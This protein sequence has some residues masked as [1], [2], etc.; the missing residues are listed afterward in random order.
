M[1]LNLAIEV[2]LE[3]L[4]GGITIEFDVPVKQI[5]IRKEVQAEKRYSV[6]CEHCGW[7]G[8]YAYP[9]GASRALKQH[10]CTNP[11]NRLQAPEKR[12]LRELDSFV[13]PDDIPSWLK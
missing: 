2:I 7:S 10:K 12:H 6:E 3:A 1:N 11:P 9:S 5:T 13:K 8:A 4:E